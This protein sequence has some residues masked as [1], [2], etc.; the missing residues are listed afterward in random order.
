MQHQLGAL[1]HL[2]MGSQGIISRCHLQT[3]HCGDQ[4]LR[5]HGAHAAGQRF[6]ERDAT[7]RP[8]LCALAPCSLGDEQTARFKVEHGLAFGVPHQRLGAGARRKSCFDSPAGVRCRQE[9]LGPG[10]VVAID[11]G[12]LGAVDGKRFRIGG[13]AAKPQAQIGRLFHRALSQGTCFAGL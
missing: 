7:D 5:E 9:G 2:G 1:A 8:V 13:Q 6:G 4:V 10:C 3:Q 12:S 11:K